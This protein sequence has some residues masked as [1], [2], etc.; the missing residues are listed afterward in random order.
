LQER[1]GSLA[2]PPAVV[3]AQGIEPLTQSS[4]RSGRPLLVT[5][6]QGPL[7]LVQGR[8]GVGHLGA[9]HW[10]AQRMGHDTQRSGQCRS[11]EDER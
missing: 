2:D 8:L 9:V 5:I 10:Q 4:R 11:G 1:L 6:V 3:V 7:Q